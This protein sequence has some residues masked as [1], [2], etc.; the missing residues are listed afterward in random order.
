MNDFEEQLHSG[1]LAFLCLVAIHGSVGKTFKVLFA[2]EA[3]SN[4]GV[5]RPTR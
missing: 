3:F 2:D 5:W 1:Y 4:G